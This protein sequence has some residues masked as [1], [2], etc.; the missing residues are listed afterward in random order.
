MKSNFPKKMLPVGGGGD[1]Y[2]AKGTMRNRRLFY[3]ATM[4][5]AFEFY[6]F[7]QTNQS[8]A[9]SGLGLETRNG[10]STDN[11]FISP[12]ERWQLFESSALPWATPVGISSVSFRVNDGGASLNTVIPRVEIT[13]STSSRTASSMSTIYSENVGPNELLVYAHDNVSLFSPGG[14]GPNPFQITFQFD[15][16]FI[17]DPTAGNLFFRLSNSGFGQSG[18]DVEAGGVNY[19]LYAPG[20]L[21]FPVGR[22]IVAQF[23]W[24]PIPEADV[25]ILLSMGFFLFGIRSVFKKTK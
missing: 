3:K 21:P 24:S 18:I 15:K 10:N 22:G 17:Y 6:V 9:P 14:P 11:V 1:G 20:V 8:V 4:I 13:M 19:A 25:S 5:V 16:L 7:S 23:S 2:L 12:N